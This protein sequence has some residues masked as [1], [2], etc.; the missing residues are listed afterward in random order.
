MLQG[1]YGILPRQ[2]VQ[3]LAEVVLDLYDAALRVSSRNTYRTGQRAYNRFMTR[4]AVCRYYPF[5]PQSLSETEL[6]LAFFMAFLLLE[7]RIRAAG[8]IL[9][10]E[11]HV[12][13]NFKEEGCPEALYT[14]QFLRQVRRGVKNTLPSKLDKRGALLLPLLTYDTSFQASPTDGRCLLLFATI[15]GFMGMLRPH[16]FAQLRPSSITLVTYTGRC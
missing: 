8:T 7:P 1:V 3:D 12:K 13:F 16:T 4:L 6:N 9:N 10:Y 14:T 15:I 2:G 11:T 5:E